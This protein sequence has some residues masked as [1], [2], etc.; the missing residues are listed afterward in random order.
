MAASGCVHETMPSVLCTT[1]RREGNLT[2]SA[3]GGGYSD[4]FE[5]GIVKCTKL[6]DV[7]YTHAEEQTEDER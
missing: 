1:L 2:K 4:L 6:R 7:D 5:R 3:E